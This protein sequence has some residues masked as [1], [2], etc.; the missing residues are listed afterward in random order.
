MDE[1]TCEYVYQL[2]DL[3]GVIDCISDEE[4]LKLYGITYFEY[5]QPN[6]EIINKVKQKVKV[7]DKEYGIINSNI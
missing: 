7:L 6:E 4:M 3:I 5:L 1:K 2:F